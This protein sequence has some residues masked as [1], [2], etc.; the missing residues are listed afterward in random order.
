ML[1]ISPILDTYIK[2]RLK[3]ENYRLK[4]YAMALKKELRHSKIGQIILR[5]LGETMAKNSSFHQEFANMEE[6]GDYQK[7]FWESDLGYLWFQGNLLSKNIY[8]ELAKNEIRKNQYISVLDVGCGWGQFCAEVSTIEGISKTVGI[9][10]SE[11]I[12]QQAKNNFENTKAIFL[13]KDILEEKDNYDLI[14]LFGSTDYIPPDI[15]KKVLLHILNL[16]NKEIIIV[17]SLRSIPFEDALKM[18]IAVEI[19]RYDTGFL[20]PLNYLLK[21]YQKTYV[22]DFEVKKIGKDSII[23]IIYKS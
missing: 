16:A 2:F 1:V 10:I 21:E 20:Q 22:F 15:F 8:F 9:D 17:N 5:N 3:S 6:K 13:H 18:N 4:I 11:N 12:I 23:A 14:T 19:K 7:M